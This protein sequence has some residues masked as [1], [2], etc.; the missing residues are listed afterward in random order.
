MPQS[1]FLPRSLLLLCLALTALPARADGP[2]PAATATPASPRVEA[3][4][5][6][7][8]LVGR[9]RPEGL[10]LWLDRTPDNAPVLEARL[11]VESGGQSA[12]AVFRPEHGD[13]LLSDAGLL[14]AL[15]QAGEHG[16]TFTL[17][18]PAREG[19]AAEEDLLL[20][21]LDVHQDQSPAANSA[22]LPILTG[23][24]L[25]AA[26]ALA[27]SLAWRHRQQRQGGAA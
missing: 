3:V 25:I 24:A 12:L 9:L 13:Y 6:Q 10:V 22:L 21:D 18:L 2:P 20:G 7:F 17:S 23:I 5:P 4:S 8:E 19:A 11:E 27:G 26:L 1:L 14:P 15:Q 16:L